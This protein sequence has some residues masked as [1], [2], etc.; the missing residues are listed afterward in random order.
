MH[1]EVD[2]SLKD[3]SDNINTEKT[4]KTISL[5]VQKAADNVQD[6]PKL[7]DKVTTIIIGKPSFTSLRGILLCDFH[8]Y[9]FHSIQ[10]ETVD[11]SLV[12]VIKCIFSFFVIKM[13]DSAIV[14]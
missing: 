1:S 3:L 4:L 7:G 9:F 11:Q 8:K 10:G 5:H 14:V 12:H 6:L 13:H 2:Q